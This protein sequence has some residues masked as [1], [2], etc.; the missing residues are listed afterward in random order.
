VKCHYRHPVGAVHGNYQPV[1]HLA[2]YFSGG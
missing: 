2:L 1:V